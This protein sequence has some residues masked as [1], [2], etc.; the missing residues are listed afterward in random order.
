MA[1]KAKA[2]W[3]WAVL[4]ALAASCCCSSADAAR[5]L[6]VFAMKGQSHNMVTEPLVRALAAR[7]HQVDVFG[8]YA[9]PVPVANISYHTLSHAG[10]SHLLSFQEIY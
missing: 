2:V 1:S 6:A 3:R 10:R 7:G 8:H 9:P 4:V 5:I